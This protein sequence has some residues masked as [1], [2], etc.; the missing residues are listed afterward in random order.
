MKKVKIAMSILLFGL[1][2]LS[3]NAQKYMV[4]TIETTP[5]NSKSSLIM[6]EQQFGFIPNVIRQMSESPNAVQGFMQ[7]FGLYEKSS[8]S[9]E[10]RWVILLVVS[11][12]CANYCVAA[13]STIAKMSGVSSEIVG[14]V[15]NKIPLTDSKLEALRLFANE[16]V[17]NYGMVSEKTRKRLFKV[18][19]TKENILDAILG[20][21]V[22]TM[23]SYT[24]RLAE[25]PLDEQFQTNAVKN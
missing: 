7:I 2:S 10:E 22:E 8:L 5:E 21:T 17:S 14:K 11:G 15:R 12:Q 24:A 25:T 9:V 1:V 4:H 19:F 18:G 6:T 3:S 13:N 20:I 23:A 16:M